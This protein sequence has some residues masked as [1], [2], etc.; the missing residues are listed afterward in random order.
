MS[1]LKRL[2]DKFNAGLYAIEE[3]HFLEVE[4]LQAKCDAMSD[5][6]EAAKLHINFN[7]DL[8]ISDKESGN[9]TDRHPDTVA[10]LEALS[11]LSE[12]KCRPTVNEMGRPD[13]PW[14]KK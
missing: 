2:F 1:N 10:L 8:Y 3:E 11:K 6:V 14:S 13:C 7:N 4:A 9:L 5:V 12:P